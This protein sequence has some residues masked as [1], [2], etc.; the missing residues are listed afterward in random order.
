MNRS[1]AVRL[2][3]AGLLVVFGASAA[4]A[5]LIEVQ[6]S[7]LDIAYDADLAEISADFD[8]LNTV[9]VSVDGASAGPAITEGISIDLLVPGVEDIDVGGATV[10]SDAGGSLVLTMD[11][12]VVD[13]E[14][15]EAEISYVELPT[16]GSVFRFAI[17][18]SGAD[19]NSASLPYGVPLGEPVSILF[20][21]QINSG[22]LETSG[23]LVTAFNASGTGQIQGVP[24]PSTL[25]LLAACG[26]AAGV[27][28]WRRR[29][30]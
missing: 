28:V 29:S 30:G 19:I 20:S 9:T 15:E 24:E 17:A 7:G 14:L 2:L 6:F 27:V 18:A 8:S 22:T 10:T 11:S 4:R 13:L 1:I 26:L 5:E 16:I 3:A 12:H 23:D 21:T 25:A